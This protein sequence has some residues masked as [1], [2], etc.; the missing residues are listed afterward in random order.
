MNA[1]FEHQTHRAILTDGGEVFLTVQQSQRALYALTSL[2]QTPL[3][4]HL[5]VMAVYDAKGVCL[6]SQLVPQVQP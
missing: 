6:W 5:K 2:A 3:A 4:L 1:P